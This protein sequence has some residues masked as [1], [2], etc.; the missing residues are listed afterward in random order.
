MLK[1]LDRVYGKLWR[2]SRPEC[3][4][5]LTHLKSLG[6]TTIVSLQEGYA[7]AKAKLTGGYATE[8]ED[9]IAM[10]GVYYDVPLSNIIPPSPGRLF[11]VEKLIAENHGVYVHCFAGVD[12]TGMSI[13]YHKVKRFHLTPEEAW[14]EAV[15]YGM[16]RRYRWW[17]P[18]FLR[19]CAEIPK[20]A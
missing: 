7:R 17:K 4:D 6:I 19:A 3:Y 12:R 5:D 9:W 13:A 2:G 10:G 16:H 20:N 8:R 14:Q 18:A 1:K 11:L 15:D